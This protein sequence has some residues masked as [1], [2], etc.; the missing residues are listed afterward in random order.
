MFFVN[1]NNG[2]RIVSGFKVND[3]AKGFIDTVKLPA[4]F[5]TASVRNVSKVIGLH[6]SWNRSERSGYKV[7]YVPFANGKPSRPVQDFL[8]GFITAKSSNNVYGRP[9]GVAFTQD[10]SLLVA[11][12]A[13]KKIWRVA[14]K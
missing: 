10:G 13:G 12:D 6:G 3:A 8:I 5:T 7:V 2:K 1:C 4:P 14:K 11:D 9:V